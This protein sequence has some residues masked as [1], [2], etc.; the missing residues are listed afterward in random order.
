[1]TYKHKRRYYKPK[2]TYKNKRKS[3][4]KK[5]RTM[6]TKRG[7][8]MGVGGASG[9]NTATT[10]ATTTLA[11]WPQPASSEDADTAAATPATLSKSGDDQKFVNEEVEYEER[12]VKKGLVSFP[13]SPANF[14]N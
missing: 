12:Q 14:F 3:H 8:M 2:E 11:I 5:K 4:L 6:R 1:M 13:N 7:G 9:P 10:A